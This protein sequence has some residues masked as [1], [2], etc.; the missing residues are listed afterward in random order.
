[1][2][3]YCGIGIIN[4]K[5]V[6]NLGTLWRSASNFDANFIFTIG[7]RY[8]K[9]QPSDTEASYKHIPLWHFDDMD[10]FR[11]HIPKDCSLIGVEIHS[12]GYDLK[13]FVHPERAIYL[14]GAEDYGLGYNELGACKYIVRITSK[15]CINVAVA[16]SIIL[17][18][19]MVKS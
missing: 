11:K 5:N 16:G 10:D 18:D 4:G 15:R 3:G 12:V 13:D 14:L 9:L 8:Q 6:L 2:R 1:M 7:H 19:R 17:Y